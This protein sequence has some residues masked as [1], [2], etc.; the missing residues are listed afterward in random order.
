MFDRIARNITRAAKKAIKSEVGKGM[1]TTID[2]GIKIVSVAV[3]GIMYFMNDRPQK[4][5]TEY[6]DV[7]P[8]TINNYYYYGKDVPNV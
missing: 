5:K 2:I 8:T 3:V 1:G 4:K 6:T 7:T